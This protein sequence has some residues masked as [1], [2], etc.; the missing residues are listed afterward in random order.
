[1]VP[2]FCMA[3]VAGGIEPL[4][5]S[6]GVAARRTSCI[7]LASRE[8]GREEGALPPGMGLVVWMEWVRGGFR[9]FC[10]VFLVWERRAGLPN[11]PSAINRE[12]DVGEDSVE[13]SGG[14]SVG[15]ARKRRGGKAAPVAVDNSVLP[16]SPS[17]TPLALLSFFR[18]IRVV[19]L[20]LL[21]LRLNGERVVGWWEGDDV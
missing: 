3:G 19:L 11:D 16:P 12:E 9:C 2:L 7:S 13:V 14:G 17:P 15:S 21:L 4:G 10:D 1:M 8:G 20:L 5:V 6:D 18:S